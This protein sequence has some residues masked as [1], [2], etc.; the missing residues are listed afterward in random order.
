MLKHC[1]SLYG[2]VM[3][4]RFQGICCVV[5]CNEVPCH[6]RFML[7]CIGVKLRLPLKAHSNRIRTLD[8][9][10]SQYK[11]IMGHWR[12]GYLDNCMKTED[13][14]TYSHITSMPSISGSLSQRSFKTMLT[15]II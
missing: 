7:E 12:A 6:H 14:L 11:Y 9:V 4:K 10:T 13:V 15:D 1:T 3:E 8:R 5:R 2:S